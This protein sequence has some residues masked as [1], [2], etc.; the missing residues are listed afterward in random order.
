[1]NRLWAV[2]F[3]HGED[4]APISA[5]KSYSDAVKVAS[6]FN[7]NLYNIIP[8]AYNQNPNEWWKKGTIWVVYQIP[9]K[10]CDLKDINTDTKLEAEL[11][12]EGMAIDYI[13]LSNNASDHFFYI[14]KSYAEGIENG[15]PCSDSN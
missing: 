10:D 2:A 8:D 12:S 7:K 3:V 9:L 11:I 14:N 13:A 15:E 6:A 1:M 4:L 5:F